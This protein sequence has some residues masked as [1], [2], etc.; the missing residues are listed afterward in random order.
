[1]S[2][3]DHGDAVLHRADGDAQIAAHALGVDHLE[4]ALAVHHRGDGLVRGVLADD[5][6]AA[7]LDAEVLVDLRL[8]DVVEVQ[9]L[10]VG[11]VR[12]GAADELVEASDSPCSSM[13]LDRPAIISC[14]ILKP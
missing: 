8:G 1:M 13:K 4:V 7:A 6:A 14:T 9:E 12:H 11:D 10:P 2:L 3:R 5:V